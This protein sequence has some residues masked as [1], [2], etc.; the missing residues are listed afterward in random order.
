MIKGPQ[1]FRQFQ[2]TLKSYGSDEYPRPRSTPRSQWYEG[3][4]TKAHSAW[5][6][7]TGCPQ[8][9]LQYGWQQQDLYE[10]NCKD[11]GLT[12]NVDTGWK[13]P[14]ECSHPQ[15]WHLSNLSLADFFPSVFRPHIAA[16]I[17]WEV[18]VRVVQ[19]CP[20]LFD[21]MDSPQDS[22]GQDT[23]VGSH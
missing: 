14:T 3:T 21:P 10:K 11:V 8:G 23:G 18:K 19:S 15:A 4:A 12:S 2:I 7:K 13:K 22:P 1:A 20:P 17:E 9:Q 6:V 16:V 5:L